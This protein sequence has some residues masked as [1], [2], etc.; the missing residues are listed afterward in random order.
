MN[1]CLV[2]NGGLGRASSGLA[3]MMEVDVYVVGLSSRSPTE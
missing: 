3:S 2:G 1:I